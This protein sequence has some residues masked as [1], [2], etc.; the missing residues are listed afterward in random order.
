MPSEHITHP[1]TNDINPSG[2]DEQKMPD[3]AASYNSMNGQVDIDDF[4]TLDTTWDIQDGRDY[5]CYIEGSS[6][7]STNSING[8]NFKDLFSEHEDKLEE[9]FV[10]VSSKELEA[11]VDSPHRDNPEFFKQNED[12]CNVMWCTWSLWRHIWYCILG[13]ASNGTVPPLPTGVH[14]RYPKFHRKSL[15]LIW[16][17]GVFFIYWYPR[18]K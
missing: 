17:L 16:R 8:Y 13:V 4:T 11:S 6:I 3:S 2:S 1:G 9:D 5:I 15:K 12:G 14:F 18:F 10:F 7:G